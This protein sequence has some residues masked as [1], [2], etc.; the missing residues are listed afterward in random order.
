[1]SEWSLLL[2]DNN[3]ILQ[4]VAQ[5]NCPVQ[6]VTQELSCDLE[7]RQWGKVREGNAQDSPRDVGPTKGI[8]ADPLSLKQCRLGERGWLGLPKCKP[9]TPHHCLFPSGG[10]NRKH[11]DLWAT[12]PNL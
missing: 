2:A 1:M 7:S 11:S 8:H 12:N 9:S 5:S 4:S 10:P 3:T 6:A